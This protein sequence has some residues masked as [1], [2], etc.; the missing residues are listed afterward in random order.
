MILRTQ[1][2]YRSPSTDLETEARRG[3]ASDVTAWNW[4]SK[5]G[6]DSVPLPD[7]S[8]SRESSSLTARRSQTPRLKGNG[9]VEVGGEG[10][11]F[12]ERLEPTRCQ[13]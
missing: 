7:P 1:E 6:A 8:W 5:L 11:A 10:S 12:P 9:R 3:T 4:Q 2:I 13:Q